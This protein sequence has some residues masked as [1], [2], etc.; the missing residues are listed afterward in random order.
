[1]IELFIALYVV[2]GL[3]SVVVAERV[4]DEEDTFVGY[5]WASIFLLWPLFW[6]AVGVATVSYYLKYGKT[7]RKEK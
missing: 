7:M 1:M 3:A 2:L 5:W 4:H 6:V